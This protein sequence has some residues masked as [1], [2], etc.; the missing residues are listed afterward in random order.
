MKYALTATALAMTLV[1]R[2]LSAQQPAPG[3]Q[4]YFCWGQAFYAYE[5]PESKQPAKI[6]FSPVFDASGVNIGRVSSEFKTY[7]QHKYS[8]KASTSVSC[9][10]YATVAAGRA[11]RQKR[12]TEV[13]TNRQVEVDESWDYASS[14][15]A[16]AAK[17]AAPAAAQKAAPAVPSGAAQPKPAAVAKPAQP[18]QPAPAAAP[19]AAAAP[20]AL[21]DPRLA[22]IMEPYRTRANDDAS[23]Q[24]REYCEFNVRAFVGFDCTKFAKVLLEYR[25]AHASQYHALRGGQDDGGFR[26]IGSLIALRELPCPGCLDSAKTDKQVRELVLGEL[27]PQLMAKVITQA[28]ADAIASC[29]VAKYPVIF[30]ARPHPNDVWMELDEARNACF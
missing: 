9:N 25:I 10:T 27:R 17:P 5:A 1:P 28:K 12:Q 15:A 7:L 13:K 8:I 30:N 22:Q 14:I 21:V 3:A 26:P 11:A 2:L 18:A 20:A 23:H 19:P 29:A 24:A 6:Y 16:A 4:H